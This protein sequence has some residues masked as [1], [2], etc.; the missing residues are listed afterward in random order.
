MSNKSTYI[1]KQIKNRTEIEELE[2]T[3]S[4]ALDQWVTMKEK[5]KQYFAKKA[6]VDLEK[7][8]ELKSASLVL[9]LSEQ[10]LLT[11]EG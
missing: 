9:D 4:N 5:S 7:Y 3:Y 1:I 11:L 8:P 6:I 10:E 2:F